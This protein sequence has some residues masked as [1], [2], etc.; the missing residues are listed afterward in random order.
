MVGAAYFVFFLPRDVKGLVSRSGLDESSFF[1]GSLVI[2]GKPS[3]S[4]SQQKLAGLKSE[5]AL[6]SSTQTGIEKDRAAVIEKLVV[7]Y[8]KKLE[9][10]Q[11][12]AFF[13]TETK[14][15]NF[16]PRLSEARLIVETQQMV[17]MQA[18]E[19]YSLGAEFEE[20]WREKFFS[21]DP[22][23]EFGNLEELRA[24][25]EAMEFLCRLL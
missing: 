20:K 17:Y 5:L 6:A 10:N 18:V 25:L 19:L 23:I 13:Q 15:E 24:E 7:F 9:V 4:V 12:S 1:S 11:R 16:C 14:P 21:I 3:E 2:L 22:S 8:Q